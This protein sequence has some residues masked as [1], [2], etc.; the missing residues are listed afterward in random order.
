MNG[1]MFMKWITTKV[2]PLAAH[3][4]PGVKMVSLMDNAPYHHVRGIPSLASFSKKSTVNLIKEQGI[5]YVLLPLT[6]ERISI[7]PKQYNCTINNGH[8]R[9][10]FNKENL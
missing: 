5:D 1:N 2:I 10:T 6:N 4:Y 3:N 9:I 7:L 8:L